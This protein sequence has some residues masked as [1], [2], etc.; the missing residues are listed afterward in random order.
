MNTAIA[1][2]TV[3]GGI[4]LSAIAEDKPWWVTDEE[5]EIGKG[6]S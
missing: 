2:L 6:S 4:A 5:R 3:V 1:A